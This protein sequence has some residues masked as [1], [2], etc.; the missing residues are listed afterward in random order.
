[1]K[2]S[3]LLQNKKLFRREYRDGVDMH[4]LKDQYLLWCDE[5]RFISV[6]EIDDL[7]GRCTAFEVIAGDYTEVFDTLNAD[8]SVTFDVFKRTA[9]K[10]LI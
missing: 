3:K 9:Y 5:G 4:I 6:L 1:M 10:D 8:R 7:D 2:L